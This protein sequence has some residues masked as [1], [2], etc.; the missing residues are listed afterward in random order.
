MAAK[1]IISISE[2]KNAF[3]RFLRGCFVVLSAVIMVLFSEFILQ[4]VW[5][6]W[7]GLDIDT[8]GRL[9]ENHWIPGTMLVITLL[10]SFFVFI[11]ML[12]ISAWLFRVLKI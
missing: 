5:A 11:L 12:K 1:H 6:K 8:P 9:I 7:L 3:H 4:V 2:G 10:A